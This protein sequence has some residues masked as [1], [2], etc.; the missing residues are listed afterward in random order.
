MI[1]AGAVALV[2]VLSFAMLVGIWGYENREDH[3]A[4]D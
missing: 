4:G 1:A 3:A 2:F